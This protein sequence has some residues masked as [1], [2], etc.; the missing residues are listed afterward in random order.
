MRARFMHACLDDGCL[1]D[2]N[3]CRNVFLPMFVCAELSYFVI[4]GKKIED[5][6]TASFSKQVLLEYISIIFI[7]Y[8]VL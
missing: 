1:V 5:E 4:W 3:Q 8:S 6:K 2:I 7:A